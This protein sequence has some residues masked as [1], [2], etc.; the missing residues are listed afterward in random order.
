MVECGKK[1][2]R[3]VMGEAGRFKMDD[4]RK[5]HKQEA[6]RGQSTNERM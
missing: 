5:R 3:G 4:K 1:L 6:V 2:F